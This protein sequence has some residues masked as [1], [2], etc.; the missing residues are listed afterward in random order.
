M[1]PENRLVVFQPVRAAVVR[2]S[3]CDNCLGTSPVLVADNNGAVIKKR[4]K[5]ALR[6]G[7]SFPSAAEAARAS[8]RNCNQGP[9]L[10]ARY[11]CAGPLGL[12][13][14]CWIARHFCPEARIRLLHLVRSI[15]SATRQA[16]PRQTMNLTTHSSNW[17]PCGS[18]GV[19]NSRPVQSG[20]TSYFVLRVVPGDPLAA[21]AEAVVA[22]RDREPL[23]G[24]GGTAVVEAVPEG[25]D[26]PRWAT[27]TRRVL[28]RRED[29]GT[30]G[31]EELLRSQ[32]PSF[33]VAGLF[34]PLVSVYCPETGWLVL[35]GSR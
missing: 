19:S 10:Q 18:A 20:C 6:V 29:T 1:R 2:T 15:H 8:Q 12:T 21:T 24:S 13:V 30:L 4:Q 7:G 5:S 34:Q 9:G 16:A 28:V 14:G 25:T 11:Y 3:L 22:G 35:D 31:L 33:A 23:A 26:G 17:S 27:C 32:I